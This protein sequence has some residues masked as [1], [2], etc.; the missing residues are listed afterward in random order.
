MAKIVIDARELRTSTGRYVE[1]LLYYLQK[2]DTKHSYI[3]LLKPTDMAGWQPT[4]PNFKKLAAPFK[5]FTFSEQLG[6]KKLIKSLDADLVHFAMVQQPIWYRGKVI[7]TMHDLTTC[8]FKNPSKNGLIFW[9]KQQ[10]YKY[11]NKRVA[12]K[13][14]AIIAPSK[15]VADDVATFA[16][17]KRNKIYV[18]YEAADFIPGHAEPIAALREKKFLFYLGRPTPHKNLGTLLEAFKIL[19]REHPDLLLVL[20]G[21]KDALYAQHEKHVK[22]MG[23]SKCVV[24]TDFV[25]EPQLKWLYQNCQAYVFPSLSEGFGLPGLEAMMHRAPVAASEATCLPEI[26]NS[27]AQYFNPLDPYDMARTIG[28]ILTNKR[29]RTEM[30]IAGHKQA[31]KYS[32][33]R[34]AEQTLKV[35]EKALS[36]K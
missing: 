11:V 10:V 24:F 27:A 21:K 4:N 23:L 36:S 12:H 5:E 25:T 20:G 22:Q 29:L 8:R 30:I 17:I 26:Y 31:D 32:W 16:R 7:T 28:E 14:R 6:F 34:M 33:A 18:T 2:T 13:S 1:R 15:F 9:F 19:R 3:V 35:Y